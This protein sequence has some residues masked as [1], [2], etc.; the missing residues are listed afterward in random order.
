MT[1]ERSDVSVG[2]GKASWRKPSKEY[3]LVTKMTGRTR[4]CA[5]AAAF[6]AACGPTVSD[7]DSTVGT[8]EHDDGLQEIYRGGLLI[9]VL[10]G[11]DF[12][13]DATPLRRS[14]FGCWELHSWVVEDIDNGFA[15]LDPAADYNVS[16]GEPHCPENNND[17]VMIYREEMEYSP[18]YCSETCCNPELRGIAN[19]YVFIRSNIAG[20][21]VVIEGVDY[22]AVAASIECPR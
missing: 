16:V 19:A 10:P 8:L 9:E 2:H 6:A 17:G 21:V 4:H 1:C 12:P 15:E 14:G 18:F 5:F 7:P 22:E 13:D 3:R 20:H 11:T